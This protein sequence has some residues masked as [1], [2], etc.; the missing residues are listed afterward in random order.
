MKQFT[1]TPIHERCFEFAVNI[2]KYSMI[3]KN[4]KQFEIAG[5]IIRSGTSICA[6]LR[7]SKNA[8][9]KTDFIFKLSIAQ[10]ETDETIFRLELIQQIRNS[11][12]EEVLLS[13]AHQILK[14]IKTISLNTKKNYEL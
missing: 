12:E 7:E 8:Y 3:L 11:D 4:E 1:P 2:V 13:E 9:S 14:I 6:N 10:K 5:Q